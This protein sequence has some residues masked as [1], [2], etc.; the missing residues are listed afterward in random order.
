MV[1]MKGKGDN[2]NPRVCDK[3]FVTSRCGLVYCVM[4]AL[5]WVVVDVEK[6]PRCLC[7]DWW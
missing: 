2:R 5:D 7:D 4:T 1:K 6:A 3:W